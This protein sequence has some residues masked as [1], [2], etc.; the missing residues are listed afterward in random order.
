MS[1]NTSSTKKEEIT[2][3]RERDAFW[4][5]EDLTPDFQLRMSLKRIMY[6]LKKKSV[7]LVFYYEKQKKSNSLIHSLKQ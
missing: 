6:V 5:V 1:D 7:F 4:F 3:A 2:R